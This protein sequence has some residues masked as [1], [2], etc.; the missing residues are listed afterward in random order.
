[1]EY[2]TIDQAIA[3]ARAYGSGSI[4]IPG[5]KDYIEAVHRYAQLSYVELQKLLDKAE[6]WLAKNAG[7]ASSDPQ[8]W[9]TANA[10]VELLREAHARQAV[11]EITGGEI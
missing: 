10:K 4:P 2:K 1:M 3:R 5:K 7:L 8:K 6:E 11:N 9:Q